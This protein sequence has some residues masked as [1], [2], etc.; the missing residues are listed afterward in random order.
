MSTISGQPNH[1]LA[2]AHR[3]PELAPSLQ[4][5]TCPATLNNLNVPK[6]LRSS[7]R[8]GGV[9]YCTEV[10]EYGQEEL[11]IRMRSYE[12]VLQRLCTPRD[13]LMDADD[14]KKRSVALT[15]E[16]SPISAPDILKLECRKCP[17][18]RVLWN[19][20][21]NIGENYRG[22]GFCRPEGEREIEKVH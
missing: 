2:C 3:S 11:G 14:D 5:Y 7:P 15:G 13:N 6:L 10:T 1:P 21:T 17:Q 12:M 18:P 22:Q 4:Q 9:V 20:G 8:S 16:G 19:R